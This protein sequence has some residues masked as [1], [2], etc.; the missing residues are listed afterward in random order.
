MRNSARTAGSLLLLLFCTTAS[1]VDPVALLQ[2][3]Y[4]DTTSVQTEFRQLQ[5]DET[6]A[7]SQTL[8]GRFW[9]LRPGK[10][11]WVYERPYRQEMVNDGERFWL[12]D[13][14]LAQ[15]TVRAS[16]EA[17]QNTPLLLLSGGPRLEQQFSLAALPASDG[18][19]WVEIRPR[20]EEGDFVSARMGLASGLPARLELQ[21]SLGQHTRILFLNLRSNQRIDPARFRFEVPPDVEVIGPETGG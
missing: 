5:I 21:D 15:V 6:G 19:D 11:R 4:R 8:E 9:M 3:F 14:D 17:L 1:A 20:A 10:L 18:L 13:E 12:Y 7:V 16:A 2:D